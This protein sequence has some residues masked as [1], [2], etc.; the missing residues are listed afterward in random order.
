MKRFLVFFLFIS[1]I[2]SFGQ[3]IDSVRFHKMV[4][5][6]FAANDLSAVFKS[7]PE[8]IVGFIGD[9]YQRIQIYYSSITKD[10]KNTYLVKG[11]SMVKNNICNFSGTIVIMNVTE[12]ETI[13][14][15]SFIFSL[16]TIRECSANAHYCFKEDSAQ[17]YSG[18]FE[19]DI[20]SQFYIDRFY[21]VH[22]DDL[23]EEAD[24]YSNNQFQGTWT[25]YDK[26]LKKKCNWGDKRIPDCGDL[27]IG[28][29]EFIPGDK[30]KNNGWE[31]YCWSCTD[32]EAEKNNVEWWK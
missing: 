6:K 8:D 22:L 20:T 24:G 3:K 13:A 16:D 10:K 14:D 18:I 31:S 30:Y 17:K 19:G 29:G 1:S 12:S 4:A 27:D 5:N 28:T 9:N 15:T 26:K 25:S 23:E 7:D 32:E 11:K 21:K 2:S